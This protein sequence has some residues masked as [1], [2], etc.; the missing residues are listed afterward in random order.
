MSIER[1]LAALTVKVENIK[2]NELHTLAKEVWQIKGGMA[3][4]VLLTLATFLKSF[5]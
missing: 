2:S 1:D 5:F 3:V 4:V